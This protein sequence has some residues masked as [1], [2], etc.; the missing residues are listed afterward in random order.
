[1]SRA[2]APTTIKPA[3]AA[4]GGTERGGIQSIERAFA[5]LDSVASHPDGITLAEISAALDLRNS[6]AFHLIKTLVGTGILA[7]DPATKR[8]R[9]GSRLFKL[10]AG[11]LDE[12]A[13]LALGMPVLEQL[14]ADTGDAAHLAVRSRDD[15]VVIARTAASGM[16]QL[17]GRTGATRPAHATAIGKVLL[18]AMPPDDLD[19]LLETLPM[20]RLTAKTITDPDALCREI[21]KVRAEGIA[22][23]RCELD[24]EV[25]CAAMPVTDFAGRCAGAIGIS[26][27][28]WK[29]KAANLKKKTAVLRRAAAALSEQLGG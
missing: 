26:G 2:A 11:A 18:A 3:R 20:P 14:S 27:P 21:A 12:N 28:A 4:S 25:S 8:Y 1:M 10:A 15:I 23:D 5:I 13:L 29:F 6:T 9:V 22:Y 16:L 24:D 7:Q 19:A 17:S